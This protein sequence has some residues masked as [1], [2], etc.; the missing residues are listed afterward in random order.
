MGQLPMQCQG[1]CHGGGGG[2]DLV[3]HATSIARW[4]KQCKYPIAH[5]GKPTSV[6]L[7]KNLT[8]KIVRYIF[9]YKFK[10][11]SYKPLVLAPCESY[12]RLVMDRTLQPRK[13]VTRHK[14]MGK[15]TPYLYMLPALVIAG[16]FCFWPFFKTIANSF[17]LVNMAGR[18]VAF[19]GLDNYK[20]LFASESFRTSLYN[21][22]RFTLMFVPSNI[23]ICMACALLTYRKR[24]GTAFNEV[25]FFLPMA[26]AMS[27]AA[28]IFKALFNPSIGVIN[29]ILGTNINWFNDPHMAMFTLVT[30]GVWLDLGLDFILLLAALRNVPQQLTEAA[31]LEGAGAWTKFWKIQLPLITPT[32]LF[33]L[34]T[35]I[36][37]AMLIS[38]PVIILTEGGPFRSTQTLVY[39]MYVEG[40]KSGNYTAGS[41]ISV[42]V[43]LLTLVLLLLLFRFERRGVYYS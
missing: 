39:Q 33:I 9:N 4:C 34:C 31:E 36:K 32:M 3:W 14:L 20:E 43:F 6:F 38:S 1:R 30:L 7:E 22:L 17:S 12:H 26:V 10:N 8:L 24:R 37:N 19:V 25:L 2:E 35:N 42:V 21:T 41:T 16:I 18:N 5:V 28:L 13:I 15:V 29:Y 27:S 23:I 11:Y 40:F